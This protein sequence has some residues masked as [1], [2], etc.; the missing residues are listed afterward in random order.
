MPRARLTLLPATAMDCASRRYGAVLAFQRAVVVRTRWWRGRGAPPPLQPAGRL[1]RR[2]RPCLASAVPSSLRACITRQW[3]GWPSAPA[4]LYVRPREW[5]QRHAPRPQLRRSRAPTARAS[6]WCSGHLS[7]HPVL[8]ALSGW[9]SPSHWLPLQATSSCLASL[10]RKWLAPG[11]CNP[12]YSSASPPGLSAQCRL[13]QLPLW[14]L[15]C[16]RQPHES[17]AP[18]HARTAAA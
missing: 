1:A 13:P 5:K 10:G 17:F 2:A 14:L 4:H 16:Y 8:T 12:H 18:F 15:P 7:T 6:G 9:F 3:S 11:S